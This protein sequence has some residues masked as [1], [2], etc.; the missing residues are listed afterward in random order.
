MPAYSHILFATDFSQESESAAQRAAD[1]AQRCTARLS[2]IHVVEFSPL[3]YGGEQMLPIEMDLEQELADE[4]RKRLERLGERMGAAKSDQHVEIGSTK[5]EILR[6][7]AATGVDLI[8][9]GSHG[10]RGLALLL[11][12]TA[13]AVLHS[14]PC[15]VLAVRVKGP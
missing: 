3:D 8:V 7:A 9:V 10:R 14:A 13:N 5:N 11:G 2:L 4:A 6:V 15:D 12:S 1:L